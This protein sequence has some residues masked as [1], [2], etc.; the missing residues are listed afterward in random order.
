M[1][2]LQTHVQTSIFTL[3]RSPRFYHDPLHYRPE[4]W[5]PCDHPLYNAVFAGDELQGFHPFSLG[6]RGCLGREMAW[7]QAKL[8]VAKVLWTF[9]VV[10]VPGQDFNLEKT[11]LHYG[12]LAKPELKVRFVPRGTL[13]K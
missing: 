1:S 7:M 12:F 4:R 9:D 8:F 2:F 13:D 11:L 3:T 6:P 5:L 10:K